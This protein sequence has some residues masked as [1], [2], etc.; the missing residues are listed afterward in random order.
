MLSRQDHADLELLHWQS[1]RYLP[2]N[3]R[4]FALPEFE[5]M[6]VTGSSGGLAP[7]MQRPDWDNTV[8]HP[9]SM[10]REGTELTRSCPLEA[11]P[12]S[13]LCEAVMEGLNPVHEG[14]EVIRLT[15]RST[16]RCGQT[17]GEVA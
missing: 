7:Q 6:S 2:A 10:S 4:F 9:S 3:E 14:A 11:I 13:Q 16:N 8:H 17:K 15:V 12:D 1:Q 5:V